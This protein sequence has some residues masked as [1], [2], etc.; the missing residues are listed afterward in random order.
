MEG[1]AKFQMDIYGKKWRDMVR[2]WRAQSETGGETNSERKGPSQRGK[3]INVGAW[4]YMRAW[5]ER[6]HTDLFLLEIF[7]GLF[8]DKW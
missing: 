1:G 4:R 2:N 3:K 5:P 6:A 8:R 7:E